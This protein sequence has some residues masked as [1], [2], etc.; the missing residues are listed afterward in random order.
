MAQRSLQGH[1]AWALLASQQGQL[2]LVLLALLAALQPLR[3]FPFP[4]TARVQQ[5]WGASV[6][7]WAPT[8]ALSS[9]AAGALLPA[10]R[11]ALLP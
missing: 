1:E 7:G 4:P 6:S 8:K 11:P 9:L 10:L 5:A 3:H 2:P